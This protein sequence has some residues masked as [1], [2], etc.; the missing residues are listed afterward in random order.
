MHTTYQEII[1]QYEA[2]KRTHQHLMER[3]V[4]ITA[5][6]REHA[7]KSVT[8]AGCGSGWCLCQSGAISTTLRTGVPA[9][10][11]AAGDLMINA[12][13]YS[14][15]LKGG[16]LVVPSRSGSTSEVI[17]AVEVAKRD[18]GLPVLAITCVPGSELSRMADL[19]IDLPWAFDASVCQTR[20]VSNLY[21]ADLMLIAF[22]GED[23]E[24]LRQIPK[25][26][27]AG[28]GYMA[29]IEPDLTALAGQRWQDIVILADGELQGLASE[30][31]LAFTEIAQMAGRYHHVLDVRHGPMVLVGRNT[32]VLMHASRRGAEFHTRLIEDLRSRGAKVVVFNAEGR[33]AEVEA[34]E[35]RD[36]GVLYIRLEDE[37]D[38]A[39]SG[40]P[41]M[42]VVQMLAYH[43][44]ASRG[45]NPDNPEGI[46]AWVKLG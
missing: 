38:M 34:L 10:A 40:I 12:P 11:L 32:L 42:N 20:T 13:L 36:R 15:M 9:Y 25:L 29:R 31:A 5:F 33:L 4:E 8:Y 27:A 3:R 28:E 18:W 17:R 35:T 7:R 19:A 41:F 24:L 26:L 45:I 44:A 37:L 22:L 30:G 2:L 23:E 16:L 1:T 6:L 21:L 14:R 43:T 46:T 39:L